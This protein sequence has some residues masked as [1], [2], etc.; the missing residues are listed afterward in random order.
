VTEGRVKQAVHL[1]YEPSRSLYGP[2]RALGPLED[3]EYIAAL[4]T[5]GCYQQFLMPQEVGS[6]QES[7]HIL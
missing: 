4:H 1:R 2:W 3:S 6:D 7:L 5:L